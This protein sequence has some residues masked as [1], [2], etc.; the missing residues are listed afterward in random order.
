[1]PGGLWDARGL[2]RDVCRMRRAAALINHFWLRVVK[3]QLLHVARMLFSVKPTNICSAH[4]KMGFAMAQLTS[5]LPAQN[6]PHL[7]D[8]AVQQ[9][10]GNSLQLQVFHH[11]FVTFV[12]LCDFLC[13]VFWAE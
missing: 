2:A 4:M 9:P 10:L 11:S 1:M 12:Y 8:V 7:K 13:A 3:R 6:V 5:H